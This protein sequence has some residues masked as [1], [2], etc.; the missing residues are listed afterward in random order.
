MAKQTKFDGWR[1]KEESKFW[2]QL[3]VDEVTGIPPEF[4]LLE[5]R[6]NSRRKHLILKVE[7]KERRISKCPECGADLDKNG[8]TY[9][10]YKSKPDGSLRI[11]FMV[12]C[13]K[14]QCRENKNHCPGEPIP[15]LDPNHHC[16]SSMAELILSQ[17][18]RTNG[19]IA[20]DTGYSDK[21]VAAFFAQ[22]AAEIESRQ[23]D[24]VF[25]GFTMDEKYLDD[26]RPHFVLGNALCGQY[27]LILEDNKAETIREALKK[28]KHLDKVKFILMDTNFEYGPIAQEFCP[29]AKIIRDYG[30]IYGL[31]HKCRDSVRKA[32]LQSATGSMKALLEKPTELWRIVDGPEGWEGVPGQLLGGNVPSLKRAHE[33]FKAFL[34]IYAVAE[35]SD[36]AV[37]LFEF[38][39]EGVK[40]EAQLLNY[41]AS[42]IKTVGDRGSEAFGYLDNGLTNNPGEAIN[43]QVEFERY[44]GRNTSYEG[45]SAR[46][47]CKAEIA[48][49][50]ADEYLAKIEEEAALPSQ[51]AD[52]TSALSATA[53]KRKERSIR[54]LAGQPKVPAEDPVAAA[55]SVEASLERSARMAERAKRRKPRS[56]A[57]PADVSSNQD[58]APP[59]AASATAKSQPH[60]AGEDPAS[61]PDAKTI[62]RRHCRSIGRRRRR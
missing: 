5:A 19:A 40:Q 14:Y 2:K 53:A 39:A 6:I 33:T 9:P 26:G 37:R 17:P 13:Q 46:M 62:V 10:R 35:N 18:D 43:R 44:K 60:T 42:L 52:Q 7:L 23:Y 28:F 45:I 31:A 30:H 3:P 56:T 47:A 36:D 29:D 16:F 22:R 61:E 54:I 20:R 34:H 51:A 4:D 24:A 48:R 50:E 27:I 12:K 25:W 59:E 41:Y 58:G 57:A 55:R 49:K 15:G 38:W 11:T 21:T 1:D 8:F 32:V